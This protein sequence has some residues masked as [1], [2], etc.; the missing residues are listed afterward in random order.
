MRIGKN[1][2]RAMIAKPSILFVC[3]DNS[4]LS[5][6]AE[7]VTIS[8]DNRVRAFSAAAQGTAP[9]DIA[10][11]ECLHAAGIA[12]DGLSSKPV[13]L[14]SL[15]GAPRVDL[16]VAMVDEAHKALRRLPWTHLLRLQGWGM[17]DVSRL[18]DPHQRRLAYRRVLPRVQHAVK[19]LVSAQTEGFAHAAA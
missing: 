8:A 18:N 11:L 13:E 9:V 1:K 19:A 2:A 10:A 6:I 7:A 17:E 14:F 16:V 5:L 4:G 15:S 12:A 3:R